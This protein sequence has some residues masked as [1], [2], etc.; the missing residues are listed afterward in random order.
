VDVMKA[1]TGWLLKA[2]IRRTMKRLRRAIRKRKTMA[3]YRLGRQIFYAGLSAYRFPE[4]CKPQVV[5]E[6]ARLLE[7]GAQV[8]VG[9]MAERSCARRAANFLDTIQGAVK[10]PIL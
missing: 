9:T 8:T 2:E 10:Y 6:C 4:V 1:I 5:S 7:E 3:V